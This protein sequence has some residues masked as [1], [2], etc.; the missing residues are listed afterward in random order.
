MLDVA[1][2]VFLLGF[3]Y[4]IRV[5]LPR[6]I[7]IYKYLILK[8]EDGFRMA[9][10]IK[11]KCKGTNKRGEPCKRFCNID[12][13]NNLCKYHGEVIVPIYRPPQPKWGKEPARNFNKKT[14]LY[15]FAQIGDR[16]W[17][18]R[19]QATSKWTTVQC[20]RM[21]KRESPGSFC[22]IHGGTKGKGN[23]N[24]ASLAKL[25]E[26]N[27]LLVHGR[28][29]AAIRRDRKI[30]FLVI[31]HFEDA[32]RVLDGLYYKQRVNELKGFNPFR[33]IKQVE[34]YLTTL[35]YKEAPYEAHSE[36]IT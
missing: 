31:R 18:R 5:G 26:M 34:E 36:D 27:V 6:K 24:P 9:K 11:R 10:P 32:I 8:V 4:F 2:S 33:N 28:E 16:N 35:G 1:C 15:K 19:C 7:L 14:G 12:A 20:Q 21:S 29:T 17:A 25:L 23:K 3:F 13:V 22:R 30:N